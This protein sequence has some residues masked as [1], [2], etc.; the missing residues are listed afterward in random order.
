MP[1]LLTDQGGTAQATVFLLCTLQYIIQSMY[2]QIH[3]L[4]A[5]CRKGS[6]NP[7]GLLIFKKGRRFDVE[8]FK[9]KS[10]KTEHENY[11]KRRQKIIEREK[12][13]NPPRKLTEKEIEKLI[14]KN[15]TL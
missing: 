12:K 1:I 14:Y 13:L 10:E 11:I 5:M 8:Q 9:W 7:Q 15:Q 2:Y 3:C 6:C 4:S